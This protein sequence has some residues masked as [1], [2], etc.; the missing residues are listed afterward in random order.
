MTLSL[1]TSQNWPTTSIL[2]SIPLLSYILYRTFSK[3]QSN[4][5]RKITQTAERVLILGGTSGI[6]KAIAKIYAIRGAKVCVVGRRDALLKEVKEELARESANGSI[7]SL[8][9]DFAEAE[10]MV[11]IRQELIDSE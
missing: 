1:V 4:R 2:A 9:G 5:T 8:K 10:D 7:L 11:R 6:G 3:R